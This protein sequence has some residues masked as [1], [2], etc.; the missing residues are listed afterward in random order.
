[1]VGTIFS[2]VRN[3]P[4][5]SDAERTILQPGY[6]QVAAGYQTTKQA[7]LRFVFQAV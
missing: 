6:Q 5:I 4:D 2:V 1:M 7:E 3:D